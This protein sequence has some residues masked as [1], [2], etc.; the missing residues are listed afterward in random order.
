MILF[1]LSAPTN[2]PKGLLFNPRSHMITWNEVNCTALNGKLTGYALSIFGIKT[3]NTER[4]INANEL[5]LLPMYNI[6]VAAL[7]SAGRGPFS[8]PILYTVPGIFTRYKFYSISVHAVDLASS[9]KSCSDGTVIG[10][11]IVAGVLL[12]LLLVSI[13]INIIL[14]ILAWYLL[15]KNNVLL[16]LFFE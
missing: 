12:M 7:N 3:H 5:L 8:N 13:T 15:H 10:L 6:S 2:T 1:S 14:I 11:G 16:V 4:K 9:N